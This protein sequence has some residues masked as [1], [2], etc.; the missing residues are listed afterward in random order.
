M[1]WQHTMLAG[2]LA[3]CAVASASATGDAYRGEAIYGRCLACHALAY[4]RVG[5]RH[6]GL[7]GRP[8]GGVSGFVYSPAMQRARIVWNARTLDRFLA[9]PRKMVPGTSM[10]YDGVPDRIERVDLIA[11]LKQAGESAEC[12]P[13]VR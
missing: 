5:P 12:K 1:S 4:D 10:T 2:G 3:L 11:Y 8:A 7:F 13:A 9:S 6:C